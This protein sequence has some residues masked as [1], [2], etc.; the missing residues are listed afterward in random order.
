LLCCVDDDSILFNDCLLFFVVE[1]CQAVEAATR[2]K[3]QGTSYQPQRKAA[4]AAAG[5]YNTGIYY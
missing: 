5:A 4:A 1:A 3:T 2:E